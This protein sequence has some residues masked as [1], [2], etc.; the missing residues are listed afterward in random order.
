MLCSSSRLV[1]LYA[2]IPLILRQH[3]V[4]G[5]SDTSVP[6]DA[7]PAAGDDPGMSSVADVGNATAAAAL[8]SPTSTVDAS[9]AAATAPPG[10]ASVPTEQPPTP[11]YESLMEPYY[12]FRQRFLGTDVSRTSTLF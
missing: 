7:D 4:S 10:N 5:Q 2:L 6:A 8:D 9:G 11:D 12:L 3:I 1:V